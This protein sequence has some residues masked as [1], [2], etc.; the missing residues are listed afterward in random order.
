[1]FSASHG[2]RSR[3][4]RL[5]QLS[6]ANVGPDPASFGTG[7][8]PVLHVAVEE[9]VVDGVDRTKSHRYGW[10]L[11]E[12]RHKARMG[13]RGDSFS[14]DLH[15][16]V[17]ELALGQPTLEEGPGVDPR[18]SVALEVH[19]VSNAS[20]VLALEEVV[21]AHLVKGGRGGVA[22]E[23]PSDPLG[24]SVRASDHDGG[25]PANEGAYPPLDV[26]VTGEPRLVLGIDGVDIGRGDRG[27]EA[28]LP[29]PSR[30]EQLGQ[31]ECCPLLAAR[32]H[33]GVE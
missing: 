20:V 26:L 28:D 4:L 12:L 18:R 6:V 15:P 33:E 1:M 21:E 31:H 29:L 19:E 16:E 30:L 7:E 10:E 32:V 13:V 5:I 2:E 27:R 17:V 25:I 9:G 11:P 14:V 22:G 23:V 3:R 24:N 8:L